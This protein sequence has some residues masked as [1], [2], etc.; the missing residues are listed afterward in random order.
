[1]MAVRDV[2]DDSLSDAHVWGDRPR[3]VSV[4]RAIDPLPMDVFLRAAAGQPR[5]YWRSDRLAAA[6]AG[7]G[8]SA[9]LTAD[10][11][12]RVARIQLQIDHL[13][14]G[15]IIHA[16][17]APKAAYPRLFGGLSFQPDHLPD[18][19]PLWRA[20]PA[21]CFLL[22]RYL[23]TQIDRQTWLTVTHYADTDE[24]AAAGD[25][26]INIVRADAA[27]F[28][29][30]LD[31][32]T[33]H[34]QPTANLIGTHY[35]TTP[36]TWRAQVNEAQDRIHSGSLKKVVL[37]RTCD[38]TFDAPPDVISAL[39]KLD[40]RYAD[41]Y[42]FLIEPEA[43]RAFFG[44]TPELLAEIRDST[45]HTAAVAGSRPRG[46]T[47]AADRALAAELLAS[48]KDRIEHQVVV[49]MLRE[50]VR[51]YAR[52]LDI[53]DQPH[54]LKLTNIQHLHTP[55]RAELETHFDALDLV[56]ELHPTPALGGYP[57]RAAML[58][59][60]EIEGFAR[61]WYASPVGWIDADG[62]GIFAVAIR[63]AVVSGEH[64]RLYA[65]AGIVAASDP[66]KEWEE[67][68]IKFKPMLDALGVSDGS[69]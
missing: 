35:L 14:D 50:R 44:A 13:F 26:P 33:A 20:F 18:D 43:G 37:A 45:L 21:A 46:A 30:E 4:V 8:A 15:A 54:V 17:G 9:V 2:F 63:S 52:T 1:M 19:D 32:I 56:G 6:Y 28:L 66:D 39:A 5:V 23:L 67:T 49:E 69:A 34:A 42:R 11:T 10:G 31:H 38:L 60:A 68:A 24:F 57:S 41:C 25:D 7:A 55:V 3:V 47:P 61:G 62:D 64:A 40:R 27:Q 29:A 48:A 59:I 36:D 51:P 22:P 12:S 65:G 53:P 58:A 16:D